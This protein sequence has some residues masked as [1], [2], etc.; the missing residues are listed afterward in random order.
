MPRNQQIY[1]LLRQAIL[2]RLL[3]AGTRLPSSREL[4]V[5]LGISRNTVLYGYEQLIAEGYLET[6]GGAGTHVTDTVPEVLG[7]VPTKTGRKPT[8][9]TARSVLSRRGRSLVAHAGAAQ[10]QWGAFVPGV[11]DVGQ[12]PHKIWSALQSRIW[13]S[14]P[15][16][17]LT[18]GVGGGYLPLREALANYLKVSR[19]VDGEP[20]QIIITSGIHQSIDLCLRLLSDP[21]DVAWVEDPCY[22]GARN[23]LAASGLE[24]RPIA[25]DG[26]GICPTP[27]QMARPPRFIFV[28]PSHQYPLGMVMSLSRRR[29]LLEYARQHGCWIIEDDYDSEFRYGGR[30]LAALQGMDMGERVLYMG[31]FSK[32]MFPGLRLGF[33]VLPETLAPAFVTG[34][35]EL[36]RSGQ[37]PLQATMAA[38]IEHG[39]FTAHIRRMRLLYGGRLDLLQQ[40]IRAE[41]PGDEVSARGSDA[42]LHLALHLP[43]GCDDVAVTRGALERGIAVRP[44][45]RYYYRAAQ[46]AQGLVLGYACV[47]PEQIAPAFAQL[48][49]AIKAQ[50]R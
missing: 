25:L 9:V 6:R 2:D 36:H 28:T 35:E 37:T 41:F 49:L 3:P 7:S 24:I 14:P 34:M 46:A 29:M 44:L 17:A 26:E 42:G 39:H 10:Q 45:S 22:W 5:Q 33:M 32:T 18:Y 20:R 12:F 40:A 47:A 4:A 16:A 19:S 50:L 43:P 11:P 27:A 21:G 8:A 48:S 15:V 31:T 30:P 1:K 13:R 23:L 38:F